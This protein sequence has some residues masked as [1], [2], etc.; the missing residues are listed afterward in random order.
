MSESKTRREIE[1]LVQAL[2]DEPDEAEREEVVRR[3]GIDMKA[4]AN[5]VRSRVADAAVKA[6]QD[7]FAAAR[8]AYEADL[9][10]LA[11][12]PAEPQRSLEEQRRVLR[13]LVAR[14]PDSAAVHFHKF[15]QATV[16]ELAEMIRA[17]RHMLG[18]D[19]G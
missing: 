5:D 8:S 16:E 4:W 9:A 3:L 12:R 11:R 14:V 1:R 10:A 13:T 18:E 7:R 6:R 2:D 17:L 19:D 15:E